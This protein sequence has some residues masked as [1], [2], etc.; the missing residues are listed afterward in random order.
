MAS[1]GHAR[2][3]TDR[4]DARSIDDQVRRCREYAVRQGDEVV[5]VFSDAATSG[6]H[7]EREGLQALLTA[8]RSR[9]GSPFEGVL[10]DDLSRLSRDLWDMGQIVFRD[11]AALDIRVIDVSN[12]VASTDASARTMFGFRGW[13]ATRSCRW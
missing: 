4:Q 1:L 11:L 7:T 13:S 6:A 9:G 10:V 2:F 3:S 8:S 5:T 12:G